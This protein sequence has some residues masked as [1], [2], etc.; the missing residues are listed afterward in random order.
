MLEMDV[1]DGVIA[2][3]LSQLYADGEWHPVAFFSKTM[4]LAEYN[5][6]IHDKEMLVIIRS[7]S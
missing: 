4:A 6:E 1:S 7:L 5:Y 2:R 3:V